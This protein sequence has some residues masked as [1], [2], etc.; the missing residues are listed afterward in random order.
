[1]SEPAEE[2]LSM[3][4]VCRFFGGADR[5]LDPS[6]IYRWMRQD[7]LPRPVIMGPQIQRWRRSDCQAVLDAMPKGKLP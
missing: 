5:P 1:M 4:E 7:R 2:M 3:R 6:T